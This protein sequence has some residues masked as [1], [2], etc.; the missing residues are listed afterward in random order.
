MSLS[1]LLTLKSPIFC[2]SYAA[3]VLPVIVCLSACLPSQVG[4]VQRR[5]NLWS[6]KQRHTIAQGLLVFWC[7]KSR[8]NSNDITPT[9]APNRGGVASNRRFSTNI[10]LYLR[11]SARQ[12]HSYYGRLIGTCMHCI[13]WRYFQLPWVTLNHLKSPHFQHFAAPF[14]SP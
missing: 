6:H 10:S 1:R 5:L 8:R 4:A 2:V 7:Q 3:T 13:K 11:N 9:G 14:I 12:G